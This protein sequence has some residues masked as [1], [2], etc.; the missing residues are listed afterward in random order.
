MGPVMGPRIYN[1]FPT[2]AGPISDWP[3]H[4]KRIAAMRFDWVYVN[5]IHQTGGSGSL[6]AVADYYRLNP[7]LRGTCARSDEALVRFAVESAAASGLDIMLDLVVNHTANDSALTTNHPQWYARDAAGAIVSPS[8]VDPDTADVTVWGDL[9]ELDYSERPARAEMVAYFSDVVRYYVGRG[10]R[11]FRCDAAYKVPGEVWKQLIAAAR[12][13]RPDTLFAAETLGCSPESVAQLAPAG[14]DYLFNS[15]KWWDFRSNWLL[16][17]YE[18][19]RHIAPSIAFPE[20]HDT[21]RLAPESDARNV[22]EIEAEY[23]FRYLFAAFFSSGVMMP[24]GYEFGFSRKLDVVRTRATDWETPRFDLQSFIT[25]ANAMKA[26]L[27]ALNEEG[28]ERL[29]RDPAGRTVTLVRSAT[30]SHDVAAAVLN[31]DAAQASAFDSAALAR[32]LAGVPRDVTPYVR[33][34]HRTSSGNSTLLQPLEMRVF[35]RHDNPQLPAA[36]PLSGAI[37][38]QAGSDVA[39]PPQGGSAGAPQ[40]TAR[41][42]AIETV[43]PQLD[44]GRHPIKRIVGER[45]SVEADVFLEGHDA[46]AAALLYREAGA[47]AWQEAAFEYVDNDRYR[48]DFLLERNGCY[49]YTIEAWPDPFATWRTDVEKKHAAGQPVDLELAQGRALVA[50]A[51]ARAT[52]PHEGGLKT[53]LRNIDGFASDDAR[54][55]A[56]LDGALAKLVA[57]APDRSAATR[58]E[59]ALRADADRAAAQFAAWYELF[60]RSQGKKPGVHGTFADAARRLPAIAAM[61]FDVVYLAP[62]H[63]IGHAFRKGPNNSLEA[64]PTDPGSPWAIGNADGGHT[65]VEP[66]LGTL[67]DFDRF[68]SAART[69]GLEVALDYALQCS[70]DH[71]YVREHPEWFAFRAD[72][73]LKYAEN[74][75]KK[76]QDIVNFDWS[77]VAAPALWNEL[78]DIVLFWIARGVR[79]FRV[80]NPHTKPFAFWEWM[81]ADVRA[82]HPE[83]IF[84]AEA[85]TR[86]KVMAELAKLGFSQSYTYFT[87]RTTKADLTA[88]VT[89]LAQTELAE[90]FRP[91]FW[92]NTPDI[93][94]ESLQSGGRPAFRSRLV[95]AATLA[96]SY[97]IYSGYELC[98]NAALAGR[99]EYADSEKY[100]IRIRDWS[101]P[102]N[103]HGEIA[104]INVIRRE[105]AALH[106]WRNV[107]FYR[108]DDD[109]VIFYGKRAADNVIL[110]AV[111]LDPLAAKDVLLWLPTGEYGIGDD[112]WYDVEELLGS[113]KHVW[114]G[115]PHRWRLDPQINPAAIFRLTVAIP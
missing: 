91:N 25:G 114:H 70:P 80:D 88:Y 64:G 75:P 5:P 74:P 48:G 87:W 60:V 65:A 93:L 40:Q 32:A 96:S 105:N 6:Y 3:S 39:L 83:T 109:A 2:L 92:P 61:G 42:V 33:A 69:S 44:C 4:F 113:T 49:E 19:F 101:A 99:E 11:G 7:L 43:T 52:S 85:F 30:A 9:A 97:G 94:P 73:T 41:V 106:D 36:R 24:M 108:A 20:S 71:P 72:G 26:A 35:A 47:F 45:V 95:L 28:S 86:P 110:V 115:S 29:S 79:I 12:S 102:G 103:L 89:E 27:P 84:L 68:V 14:F 46:L 18:K 1:L 81:I 17:Q 50:A 37:L 8:A 67:E 13:V 31:P 23:R 21:P 55:E 112:D 63:P 53:A 38:P 15:S 22:A 66:K 10:I 107:T 78:R 16:E 111:N 77:S 51:L 62:I 34:K 58:Y 104:R 76:Y 59:P 98:E 100:A 90:Y 56:L 82:Q 54:R 57:Q